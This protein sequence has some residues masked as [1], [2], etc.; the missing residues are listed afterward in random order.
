[1]EFQL[2]DAKAILERTPRVLRELLGDL[3]AVWTDANEGADTWSPFDVVGHLIHGERT[4]WM[5]RARSILDHGESRVFEPFDRFAMFEECRGRSLRELL[6][7][8]ERL[9]GQ[10]LGDLE[11]L[12]LSTADLERTGLHPDFG[13]VTLR[14]LLSTWVVHDLGHLAQV[15]RTMAKR[16]REEVGPWREYLPVLDTRSGS[17]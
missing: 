16:Y 15:S 10:N 12:D 5:G 9:R 4:D 13:P 14:Q 8:F 1:M 6:E 3:E 11:R 2:D 17:G 7:T